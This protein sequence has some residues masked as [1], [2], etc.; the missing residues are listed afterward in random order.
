MKRCQKYIGKK[1]KHVVK[2]KIKTLDIH[3]WKNG[4][5]SIFPNG[6][7]KGQLKIIKDFNTVSKTEI[8]RGN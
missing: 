1:I 8:P 2:K 5:R 7:E 3:M 4:N 6:Q